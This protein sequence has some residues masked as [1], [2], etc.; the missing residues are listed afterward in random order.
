MGNRG[1]SY[2]TGENRMKQAKIVRNSE[3]P[4]GIAE[5]REEELKIVGNKWKSYGITGNRGELLKSVGISNFRLSLKSKI[6]LF[7][8]IQKNIF[9]V[10][11]SYAI[12]YE[13]VLLVMV[14]CTWTK[15][16]WQWR[17]RSSIVKVQ[18]SNL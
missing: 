8:I 16:I 4:C 6:C 3:K 14:I 5:N 13:S 10:S 1:K 2:E 7:L 17:R 12:L 9:W 11:T 15:S 18:T